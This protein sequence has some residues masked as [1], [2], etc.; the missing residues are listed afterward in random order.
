[1]GIGLANWGGKGQEDLEQA[2]HGAHQ[3]AV[4]RP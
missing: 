3:G 1:M 2:V 4:V